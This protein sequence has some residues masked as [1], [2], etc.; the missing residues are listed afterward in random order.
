[1]EHLQLKHLKRIRCEIQSKMPGT[2]RKWINSVSSSGISLH[3][4]HDF[5]S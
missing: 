4:L 1:M 2:V 5:H 3:I